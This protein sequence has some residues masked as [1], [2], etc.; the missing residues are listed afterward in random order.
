MT[1]KTKWHI[2]VPESVDRSVRTYL[3]GRGMK[4]GDLSKFVEDAVRREV[5]R[6]TA[7]D[8]A[9]PTAEEGRDPVTEAYKS[10]LDLSLLRRNLR[11]TPEERI[12]AAAELQRLAQEVGRAGRKARDKE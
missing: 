11:K 3:A 6:R 10:D 12:L 2:S 1:K 9:T 4:K 8:A 5:S 7:R